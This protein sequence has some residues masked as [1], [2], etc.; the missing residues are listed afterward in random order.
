MVR[1]SWRPTHGNPM[2]ASTPPKS[3][4]MARG[5]A[6]TRTSEI[7]VE[8]LPEKIRRYRSSQGFFDGENPQELVPLEEVQK[9]YI[10]HVL[11]VAG[12]NRTLASRVLG[13]DRKTLYNRLQRYGALEDPRVGE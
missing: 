6:L 11:K 8:D 3:M 2:V 12:G 4:T 1:S 13:V 7:V 9:R 10:L 5:V